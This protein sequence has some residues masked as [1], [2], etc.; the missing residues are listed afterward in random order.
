VQLAFPRHAAEHQ[1]AV[2]AILRTV[3][4]A[5]PSTHFVAFAQ[6]ILHRGAGIELAWSRFLVVTLIGGLFLALALARFRSVS[7]QST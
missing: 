1:L 3:M 4:Q 7:S 2:P 5:S 6:A